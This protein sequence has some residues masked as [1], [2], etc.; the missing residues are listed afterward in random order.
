[1]KVSQNQLESIVAK[2][3][4]SWKKNNVVT[5]KADEKKVFSRAVEVLK[6]ELM[7]E[8][9]LEKEVNKMLDD[10][11]KTN[12]GQFQRHKM[13]QMIRQKLAAQKKVIL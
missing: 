13:A 5:F 7:K 3:F 11:E 10:L 8:A 2:V 1:M 12:S 4:E 6:E 9:E